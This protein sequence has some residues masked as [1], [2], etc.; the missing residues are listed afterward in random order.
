[1]VIKGGRL[2]ASW[3][4]SPK[5]IRL[6]ELL[7]GALLLA[8]PPSVL[9]FAT[10]PAGQYAAAKKSDF[11]TLSSEA[12]A[13]RDAGRLDQAAPLYRKALAL[14][15]GWTE[16]WWALGTI[17]YDKDSYADA[18]Q[19]FQR[20]LQLDPKNGTA[21]L[22]LALC[23]Y[24]L[25]RDASAMEH[26]QTA[27]KLGVQKDGDLQNVLAYHEAM[28]LLR[29]GR[30]ERALEALQPLVAAGVDDENVDLALGMAVLLMRPKTG[31]LADP[32][33]RQ[34]V[35][36]AGH[37]ERLFL[38]K[39]FDA[40]K[41]A[42]STLVQDV[43]EFPNVHYAYGRF[44]LATEDLEKGVAQFLEQIK[45]DPSHV[46]ARMLIAA[47]RY[48]VDSAAGLPFAVEVV[49]LHPQY[50]FGHY[51]LGL[52]YFDTDDIV[53]ATRELETA[54]RMVPTEAQFQFALGNAYARAG[55]TEDAA[56][57][58]AAFVRLR[59]EEATLETGTYDRLRR[60]DLDDA[61]SASVKQKGGR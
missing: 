10:V 22:M 33:G 35:L 50:P 39:D 32:T 7:T 8:G 60:R 26:I 19:A 55:R 6:R 23:D 15:P 1:V 56:R 29:G 17:L 28:L 42:Y 44:L 47:A 38:A 27:K 31:A 51:L 5:S 24:Q 21:H 18:A 4:D 54:A 13:A 2:V 57:A 41:T 20:V 11:A 53:R 3:V 9:V 58:R 49:K 40:A 59:K 30:Y 46:R 34:T 25:D 52:L 36:R 43:P 48:R 61:P 16:G 14:R 45:K 12:D 37:A